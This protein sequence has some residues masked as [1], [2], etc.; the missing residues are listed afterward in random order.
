MLKLNVGASRKIADGAYGSRGACVHVELELDSGLV[1]EP[2]KLQEKIRQLFGLVRSSL[3]EELKV[4]SGNGDGTKGHGNGKAPQ[5]A[6]NPRNGDRGA[7]Q[8]QIKALY[9][10]SKSNNIDLG[11]LLRERFQLRQPNDLTI[12]EASKLIDELKRRGS[13]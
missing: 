4:H 2:V 3:A 12:G 6:A 10:I 9:A 8:S 11:E 7:T 13:G 5:E 1:H